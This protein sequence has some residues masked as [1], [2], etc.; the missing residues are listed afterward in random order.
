MP[1]TPAEFDQANHP[2]PVPGT[3]MT[4]AASGTVAGTIVPVAAGAGA[5]SSTALATGDVAT[6]S[7][8]VFQLTAAGTPAAGVVATINLVNP[9]PAQILPVCVANITDTTASP[10]TAVAASLIPVVTS[11]QVSS[12]NVVSA[13]LTAAHVYQV[14][15]EV[16]EP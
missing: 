10:N 1:L 3:T 13:V 16:I 2:I 15:Y 4:A 8:G 9:F 5:G 11:G 12:L 7:A 14:E 6:D